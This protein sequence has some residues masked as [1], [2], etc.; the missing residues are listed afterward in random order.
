MSKSYYL[1]INSKNRNYDEEINDFNVFLSNPIICNYNE[2][3]NVN[4]IGFSMINSVYNCIGL[5]FKVSIYN[6]ENPFNFISE[7]I[8]NIPDGNYSHATLTDLLNAIIDKNILTIEYIKYKNC[9]KFTKKQNINNNVYIEPFNCNKILGI[10]ESKFLITSTGILSNYINL[11]N[12]SHIIIK[13]NSLNFNDCVQDNITYKDDSLGIS[14]ILFMI[15]KQDIQPFQ[16]I[17]YDNYNK[18]D[19]FSY[20]LT[21]KIINSIDLLLYNE[22]NEPL[23]NIDDYIIILKFNIVN[24]IINENENK[25]ILEDIRFLIM[26]ALFNENKNILL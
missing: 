12:Y 10:S 16:M 1:Y 13:S 26:K 20:N 6:S 21:N 17:K 2:S 7:V 15:D 23:I 14:N 8:Y 18:A 25:S 19:T 5:Y 22:K 9:F 11:V 24:N 3:L 4:V